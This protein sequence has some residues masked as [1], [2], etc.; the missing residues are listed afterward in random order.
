MAMWDDS[1]WNGFLSINVLLE[2]DDTTNSKGK[3]ERIELEL[4]NRRKDMTL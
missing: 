4:K 2:R 3:A 1:F